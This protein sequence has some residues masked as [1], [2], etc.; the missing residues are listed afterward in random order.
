MLIKDNKLHDMQ[1]SVFCTPEGNRP[2][3][4]PSST[5]GTKGIS[6]GNKKNADMVLGSITQ[7]RCYACETI[8][9]IAYNGRM[10]DLYLLTGRTLGQ[11]TQDLEAK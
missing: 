1:S 10:S 4:Q 8:I 7:K 5:V 2:L 11:K 6:L 9:V 3:K